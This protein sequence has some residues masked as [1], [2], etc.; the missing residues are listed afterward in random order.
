MLYNNIINFG[1][2][3][4][5]IHDICQSLQLSTQITKFMSQLVAKLEAEQITIADHE[6]CTKFGEFD[7]TLSSTVKEEGCHLSFIDN[8]LHICPTDCLGDDQGD[9]RLNLSEKQSVDEWVDIALVFIKDIL[10]IGKDEF[11]FEIYDFEDELIHDSFQTKSFI[12]AL[13]KVLHL[14]SIVD[15]DSEDTH[16]VVINIDNEEFENRSIIFNTRDQFFSLCD[17]DLKRDDLILAIYYIEAL[18]PHITYSVRSSVNLGIE[19]NI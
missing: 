15:L 11:H 18:A 1:K 2:T 4:M 10:W 19:L 9:F 13:Y 16:K 5:N 6:V 17:R 3:K 14:H 12:H 8:Q 7:V